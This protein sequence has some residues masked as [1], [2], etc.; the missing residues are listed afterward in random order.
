MSAVFDPLHE[1]L[2]RSGVGRRHA[3]RYVAELRDHLDDL[4]AEEIAAGREPGEARERA[5]A[6]LGDTD[7]LAQ[8][9]TARAEFRAWT[10]RAP[11]AAYVL[12]PPLALCFGIAL[13]MCAIVLT[14]NLLRPENSGAAGL[15][16][17]T[18]P[19]VAGVVGV[20][21]A[22]LAVLVGWGLAL[23]AVRN[24]ASALWPLIGFVAVAAVGAAL[25]VDVTLPLAGAPGEVELSGFDGPLFAPG[26]FGAR[27]AVDLLAIF[28][29]YAG[30]CVWRSERAL[31][32]RAS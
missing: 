14:V 7:A 29:A 1:R 3:R 22:A 19:L 30:L 8:A 6:R 28:A 5:M 18:P 2:L 15:P 4:V 16:A 13:A 25:Q 9:M 10:A 23:G 27:F 32:G 31:R 26:G 11:A 21:N 17:W 24:R 12:A 20:V